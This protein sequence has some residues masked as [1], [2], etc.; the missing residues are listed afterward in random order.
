MDR[1]IASGAI[2]REFESL[3]AHQI[4][5]CDSSTSALSDSG[6]ILAISGLCPELCPPGREN[7]ASAPIQPSLGNV[8][9][10]LTSDLS[11]VL[12]KARHGWNLSQVGAC[13]NSLT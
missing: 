9:Q 4:S 10:A 7:A 5:S 3:R 1:A 8:R 11:P 12:R 2:G 13:I 6:G